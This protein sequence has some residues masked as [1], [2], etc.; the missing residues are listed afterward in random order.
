MAT[1]AESRRSGPKVT[2]DGCP[3]A[4]PQGPRPAGHE[5]QQIQREGAEG[6]TCP[7]SP[8]RPPTAALCQWP[9]GVPVPSAGRG[10]TPL[11]LQ[12]HEGGHIQVLTPSSK[13]V[14]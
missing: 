8:R 3:P 12:L 11:P 9:L 5:L 7:A 6:D 2:W 1:K 10:G 13:L 14:T 4:L